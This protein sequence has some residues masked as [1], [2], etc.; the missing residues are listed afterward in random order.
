M[1][2]SVALGYYAMNEKGVSTELRTL[3]VCDTW[4]VSESLLTVEL[5]PT[6]SMMTRFI[7]LTRDEVLQDTMVVTM[8]IQ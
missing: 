8:T 5:H 2:V 3:G 6:F 4:D 7:K 1:V